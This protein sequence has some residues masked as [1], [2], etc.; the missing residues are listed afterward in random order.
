MSPTNMTAKSGELQPDKLSKESMSSSGSEF[1]PDLKWIEKDCG[2]LTDLQSKILTIFVFLLQS[3]E[4][5]TAVKRINELYLKT[6]QAYY[7]EDNNNSTEDDNPCFFWIH[8]GMLFT[9]VRTIPYNH[10]YQELLINFVVLL[11]QRVTKTITIRGV[12][13]PYFLPSDGIIST[14]Y[15]QV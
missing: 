11:H 10:P 14:P 12:C 15:I 8:W 2:P 3:A 9:L 4:I 6:P 7:G 13:F 5:P 1:T